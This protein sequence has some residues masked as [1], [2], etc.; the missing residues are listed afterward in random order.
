MNN[1]ALSHPPP[2]CPL[3]LSFNLVYSYFQ[4][5]GDVDSVIEVPG[6]AEVFGRWPSVITN[7]SLFQLELH[8]CSLTHPTQ[9]IL[10]HGTR[11]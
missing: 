6:D 7:A 2:S 9:H 4:R 8:L 5:L 1:S 10:Q 11:Q 3:S